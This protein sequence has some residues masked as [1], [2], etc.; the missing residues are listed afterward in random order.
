MKIEKNAAGNAAAKIE[1]SP[2][3]ITKPG[4]INQLTLPL[5]G[6]QVPPSATWEESSKSDQLTLALEAKVPPTP[7][8]LN[9]SKRDLLVILPQWMT[10]SNVRRW[11]LWRFEY[12]KVRPLKVPYYSNGKRRSGTLDTQEDRAKMASFD[13]AYAVFETGGYTGL[14]FALGPDDHDGYWQG[15]DL[16]HISEK[17]HLRELTLP[18]YVELSPSG[19]GIHAIG[20]GRE[21]RKL[22]SGREGSG[23]ETSARGRYFTVTGAGGI[24]LGLETPEQPVDC[25]DYVEQTLTPLHILYGPKTSNNTLNQSTKG[26]SESK[27]LLTPLMTQLQIAHVKSALEYISPDPREDWIVVGLALYT[28]GEVG[29]EIW[30]N[31]SQKSLNF[32]EGDLDQW[33]TFKSTRSDY[34]TVFKM[35]Q[36]KGWPN[37]LKNPDPDEVFSKQEASE[38]QPLPEL[39]SVDL[40]DYEYLPEEVRVRVRDISERMQ[41]PPDFAAVAVYA[42]F[43]TVLGHKIGIRPKELDNWTVTPNLWAAAIGRS[44]IK[45]SPALK[46]SLEPLLILESKAHDEYHKAMADYEAQADFVKVQKSVNNS[47]AKE[48][49]TKNADPAA[50]RELLRQIETNDEP[51]LKRYKT[52]DTTYEALGEVLRENPNGIMVFSDELIGLLKRLDAPGQDSSRGF[53]LTAADGNQSV[54]FDRIGRGKGLRI[55]VV[56]ISILGGIQPG[57][58]SEYV[59]QAT[60]GGVGADGLLQRFGLMVYPDISLDYEPI[61]RTPNAFARGR[62]QEIVQ[63]LDTLDPFNIGAVSDTDGSMPFLRLDEA[64][65][66]VF[67]EWD[68]VLQRRIR[69]GEEHPAI[70]SHLSKYPKLILSLALI[71]HLCDSGQGAVS[72]TALRRAIAY[73]KYLESHAQRVYSFATRPENEA[74][75]TLLK[76][77]D[78]GKLIS[79]FKARDVT[80]RGWAGLTTPPEVQAAIGV[81]LEYGHLLEEKLSSG[82]QGGRPTVLYHWMGTKY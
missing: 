72:E 17:P 2:D 11:L 48:A 74:A 80:Q 78:N 42:M 33:D 79:P 46:E 60:S 18:G 45:K 16:D 1:Q 55:E 9:K 5:D 36:A 23:I 41:C 69:S 13:E 43:S 24:L 77:L 12:D 57:V 71:N 62:V 52:N 10:D 66:A 35:A 3:I 64:A 75:K 4:N 59:R 29:R 7:Y 82:G 49:I 27:P 65:R 32:R 40:F 34:R 38:P 26:V 50:A 63:R 56:C 30:S 14:G 37:P 76:R 47:K 53:Y 25:F 73:G 54:T 15:I 81:L 67:S 58:L 6:P 39:P 21:F 61:D 20:Y 68:T 31:W 51:T 22:S 44:G 8:V 28:Q 70:V 19:D